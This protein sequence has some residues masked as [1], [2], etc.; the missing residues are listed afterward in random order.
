MAAPKKPQ[1]VSARMAKKKRQRT[2]DLPALQRM[3]WIALLHAQDVLEQ[4]EESEL[5][6]KAIHA[7][8]Q[9]AGQYA[10]LLEIGELEAR[11]QALEQQREGAAA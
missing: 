5:R 3:V 6:L 10:K 9:C 7:L 1:T 2:G 11:V 8:S 4:A